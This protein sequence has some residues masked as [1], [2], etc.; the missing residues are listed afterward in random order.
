MWLSP[1]LCYSQMRGWAEAD[2]VQRARRVEGA[3]APVGE[4]RAWCNLR[5]RSALEGTPESCRLAERAEPPLRGLWRSPGDSLY[6]CDGTDFTCVLVGQARFAGWLGKIA[7]H[8][9]RFSGGT[10]VADQAFRN[11]TTGVLFGWEPV[12]ITLSGDTVVKRFP[13][14]L[15]PGQLLH[16]YTECYTRVQA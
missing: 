6:W 9:V 2:R 16:G 5:D 3:A 15:S 7:V 4:Q 12:A 14:Y 10:G 11:W 13:A 1:N 8:V